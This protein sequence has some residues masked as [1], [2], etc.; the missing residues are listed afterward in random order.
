M[1][2]DRGRLEE[3][4][5]NLLENAIKF[6]PPEGTILLFLE[7]E[8]EWAI[9]SVIDNGP[10]IAP[11]LLPHLF[12]R[13]YRGSGKH[14]GSGFGSFYCPLVGGS[15]QRNYPSSGA[16]GFSVGRAPDARGRRGW[17]CADSRGGESLE[18]RR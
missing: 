6:T 8:A 5:A 9:L 3:I 18:H 11:E 17:Q 12:E 4:V 10:G 1:E 15:A 2:A 14:R 13:F 16:M 7:T